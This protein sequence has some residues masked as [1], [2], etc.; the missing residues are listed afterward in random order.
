MRLIGH[1]ILGLV[2]SALHGIARRQQGNQGIQG[3][4]NSEQR[5]LCKKVKKLSTRPLL[6]G[7]VEGLPQGRKYL[8]TIISRSATKK[9]DQLL[10]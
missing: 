7:S 6:F 5:G 2:T 3:G 1:V 10:P 8:E 9:A 4:S